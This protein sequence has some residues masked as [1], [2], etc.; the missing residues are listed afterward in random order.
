MCDDI[1][2]QRVNKAAGTEQHHVSHFKQSSLPARNNEGEG[3]RMNMDSW[4][5]LDA[6]YHREEKAPAEQLSVPLM[7]G[8]LVWYW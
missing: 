3:C 2:K 1:C 7:T 6:V 8:W 4:S 5:S